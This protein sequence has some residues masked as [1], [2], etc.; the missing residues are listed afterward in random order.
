LDYVQRPAK[1]V[2]EIIGDAGKIIVDL[3]ELTLKVFDASGN[4]SESNSY[5]GFDRNQ[6]FI[7]ELKY[8]FEYLQGEQGPLVTVREAAQSLRIALAAKES[9]Q[10]YRVVD[11][12]G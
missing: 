4:L 8:Y 7:N 6:L 12:V 11:L 1:R 9:L 3:R 5:E 2:C 10:T